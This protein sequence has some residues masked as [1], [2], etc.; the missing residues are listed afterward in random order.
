MPPVC[1][2]YGT[3]GTVATGQQQCSVFHGSI[4]EMYEAY[5]VALIFEPYA[6]DIVD[7]VAALNPSTVLELAAGT[8]VVTRELAARLTGIASSTATDLHPPIVDHA[9][10]I[11]VTGPVTWQQ[12]D[13][14]KLPFEDA[15]FDLV[16]C[17]FGI[18][19]FPDKV[20]GNAEGRRVLR[21]RGHY[22]LVIWDSVDRNPAT[23]AAGAAVA[24]LFPNDSAAFYERIP[25]RYFDR[26][27]IESEL[28]AAGFEQIAFE[29]VE[30]RS[31]AASALDAA[32][33]LTQGTPM[34]SEIES[35]DPAL[36]GEATDAAARALQQ[37]EGP[38]G[39]DAPMSAHIVVATK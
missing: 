4:P 28:R 14:L 8:G 9:K 37:F 35:R 24:E 22:L 13:A 30:L 19:F 6:P 36:L 11:G 33:G 31:R 23:K 39:F 18:M 32:I 15:S 34:R 17:Q 20:A 21:E 2:P 10:S 12:A 3:V 5:M 38:A 26:A 16:V 29:T 1:R 27:L 7:R 25:F